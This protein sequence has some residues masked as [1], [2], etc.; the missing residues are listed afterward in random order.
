M[1]NKKFLIRLAKE[2]DIDQVYLMEREYIIEHEN[3]QLA[4]WD[5]AKERNMKMLQDNIHQMFVSTIDDKI[6]GFG[7]WSIHN[8]DPCVFSIYI[9]KDHRKMGMAT[10]LMD[11]M[12][13]QIHKSG[14]TKMTLSTLETNP[15]Q[16]LFNKLNYEEIGRNDGWIN[17]E[18]SI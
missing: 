14:Y 8:D 11:N 2:S 4:R 17:Y 16:Y 18:K 10:E 13:K 9:S 12:E 3:E 6:A 15:A 5:S 1:T 7:Y